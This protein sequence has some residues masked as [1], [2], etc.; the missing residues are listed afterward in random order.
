[1][2]G[3]AISSR[4]FE[5][6]GT[7]TCQILIE[8]HYNGV[9]VADEHYIAVRKDLSNIADAVQRFKDDGYRRA[10]V[11]RTYEHVMSAHTYRHR[12]EQLVAA[13]AA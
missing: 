11:D 2:S 5:P 4:H 8:G 6:V 7:K 3:K 1:M 9:L 12:V 13:V 10:M